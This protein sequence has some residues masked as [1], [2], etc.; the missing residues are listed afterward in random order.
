MFDSIAVER[1]G[2]FGDACR[3]L[4]GVC[5]AEVDSLGVVVALCGI[6]AGEMVRVSG[7]LA[8]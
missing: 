4:V 7:M 5:F 1:S 2:L 3:T 8:C 6:T